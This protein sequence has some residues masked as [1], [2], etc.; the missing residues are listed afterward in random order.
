MGSVFVGVIVLSIVLMYVFQE[1]LPEGFRKRL[2]KCF[3]REL[4]EE[5]KSLLDSEKA[6][7][8]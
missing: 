5:R 3:N 7:A 4:G 6:E 8:I 2:P 1:K